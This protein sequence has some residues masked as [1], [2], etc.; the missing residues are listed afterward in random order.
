[1]VLIKVYRPTAFIVLPTSRNVSLNDTA[2]FTC[3]A[4]AEVI[5]WD[6]DGHTQTSSYTIARGITESVSYT[7]ESGVFTSVLTVPCTVT[8]NN[9]Q[10][11]CFAVDGDEFQTSSVS[12][13]LIQGKRL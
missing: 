3:A 13:L 5:I 7:S 6:I 10:L 12:L 8:N 1:M 2:T 11:Q 9:T 4:V